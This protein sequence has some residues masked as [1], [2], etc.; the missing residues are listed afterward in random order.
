L[1]DPRHKL[2]SVAA[3]FAISKAVIQIFTGGNDKAPLAFMFA[4]WTRASILAGTLCEV[5]IQIARRFGDAHISAVPLEA[6]AF[7][8]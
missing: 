1:I 5:Q 8:P 7:G 2:Q 4:D 6:D 3:F